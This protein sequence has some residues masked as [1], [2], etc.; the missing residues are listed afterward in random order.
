MCKKMRIYY[1]GS[2]ADVRVSCLNR[3]AELPSDAIE[4]FIS[5]NIITNKQC[6]RALHVEILNRKSCSVKIYVSPCLVDFVRQLKKGDKLEKCGNLPYTFAR[7]V[8]LQLEE[9]GVGQ[10]FAVFRRARYFC[11][12]V[13]YKRLGN[14]KRKLKCWEDPSDFVNEGGFEMCTKCGTVQKGSNI[15]HDAGNQNR[16][17]TSDG[18]LN[19]TEQCFTVG[20]TTSGPTG[21]KQ[22]DTNKLALRQ[23]QMDGTVVKPGTSQTIRTIREQIAYMSSRYPWSRGITSPIEKN[24][25]A[26][27]SAYHK[28]M[29]E[30]AKK[31]FFGPNNRAVAF[32]WVALVHFWN[33]LQVEPLITLSGFIDEKKR[34]T[35]KRV[36]DFLRILKQMGFF[37]L[38]IPTMEEKV[39]ITDD[40]LDIIWREHPTSYKVLLPFDRSW[41]IQFKTEKQFDITL[42][43]VENTV[44]QYDICKNDILTAI[45]DDKYNKLWTIEN[46]VKLCQEYKQKNKVVEL[47]FARN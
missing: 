13:V 35:T 24:A 21:G 10:F 8:F 20:Q 22:K 43:V 40:F 18:K 37:K 1:I 47:T 16:S 11:G 32:I 33:R 38:K 30:Q 4:R 14:K 23:R 3:D 7:D 41:G 12:G 6:I 2:G 15:Q 9:N 42:F 31:V 39:S 19:T 36:I 46:V 34:F 29:D 27:C 45:G 44:I 28:E 17:L 26:L 25:I 5:P